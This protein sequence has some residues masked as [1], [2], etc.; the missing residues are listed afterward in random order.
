MFADAGVDCQVPSAG[1]KRWFYLQKLGFFALTPK[2]QC[3]G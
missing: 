2:T 1:I 3:I